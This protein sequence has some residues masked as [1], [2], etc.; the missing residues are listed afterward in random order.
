MKNATELVSLLAT[1]SLLIGCSQGG[2]GE[3]VS[4]PQEKHASLLDEFAQGKP[5]ALPAEGSFNLADSQRH[6]A[7]AGRADANAA[8]SGQA[9]CT[10]SADAVGTAEAEFQLGHVLD[11][12]GTDPLRI[13]ATFDVDYRCRVAGDPED[14]T[15]PA[16]YLGLRV[17]IRDSN[18]RVSHELTLTEVTSFAGPSE[19]SGRQAQ[20]FDVTLEPGLAYYF[21][22]AGRT[23]VAG[24]EAS[25]ASAEIEVRSLTIELTPRR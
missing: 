12:R 25:S 11:N 14:T 24:T 9:A 18:R 6:S 22:L 19:W 2:F 5:L 7:G 10:A 15:K 13:N 8:E 16:D 4:L 21:V 23:A 20:S 1:C 17:F 3:S